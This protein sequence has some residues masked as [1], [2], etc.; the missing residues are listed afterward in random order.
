MGR[1][2]IGKTVIFL[3]VLRGFAAI[4]HWQ[5]HCIL[6]ACLSSCVILC[7]TFAL[8]QMVVLAQNCAGFRCFFR[9]CIIWQQLKMHIGMIWS[10]QVL[11]K[12]LSP[13]AKY[14]ELHG[15]LATPFLFHQ[16]LLKWSRKS[17]LWTPCWQMTQVRHQPEILHFFCIGWC[18]RR[19]S[20]LCPGYVGCS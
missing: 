12:I 6:N 16:P 3:C 17:G 11:Q 10:F 1:T 13:W 19:V 7:D 5:G 15:I 18:Q 9:T 20:F 2:H 8:L 14:R 4:H